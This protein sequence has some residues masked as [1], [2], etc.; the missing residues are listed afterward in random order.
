MC[1]GDAHQNRGTWLEH[2]QKQFCEWILCVRVVRWV[3]YAP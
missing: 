3:E 1:Y 2:V